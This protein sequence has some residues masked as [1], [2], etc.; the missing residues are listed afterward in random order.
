MT[1]IV[2]VLM[3]LAGILIVRAAKIGFQLVP[4]PRWASDGM[5]TYVLV[6]AFAGL[7]GAG[8]AAI[9]AWLRPGHWRTASLETAAG[10]ALALAAFVMLWR[11]MSAWEKRVRPSAPVIPLGPTRDSPQRVPLRKAA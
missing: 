11:L 8:I 7:S 4:P 3:I 9:A 1:A 10:I 5:C 2:G 6:P